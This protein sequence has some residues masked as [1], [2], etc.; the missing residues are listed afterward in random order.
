MERPTGRTN[1]SKIDPQVLFWGMVSFVAL[2]VMAAANGKVKV[3]AILA[4]LAF[5]SWVAYDSLQVVTP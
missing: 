1:V 5:L 2:A 4:I 3:A